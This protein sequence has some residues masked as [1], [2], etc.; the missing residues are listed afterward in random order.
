MARRGA[1][2]AIGAR[3]I[4]ILASFLLTFVVARLLD[5]AEA[6]TFFL[7]FT[8][9]AIAATFGRFGTDN[10]ALKLVGGASTDVQRDV[11]RLVVITVAA[12]GLAVVVGVSVVVVMGLRLPGVDNATI[13]VVATAVIPQAL[14]VLAGALLR[15][16]G[17]LVVGTFAE[18]GSLPTFA[19]AGMLAYA[20]IGEVTLGGSLYCLAGASWLTAVWSSG[21]AFAAMRSASYPAAGDRSASLGFFRRYFGQLFPMMGTSLI[22]Y[23]V[24]W[25]PIYLLTAVG[26]LEAV[27]FYT[28]AARLAGFVGLIPAIQVSYLAPTFARLYQSGEIASLNA[29]A[30]RSASLALAVAALPAAALI[31]APGF[32]LHL[33]YGAPYEDASVALILL[34]VGVIITVVAGQVNQ[35]MLLC[36]LE[37]FALWLNIALLAIWLIAG[38][39]AADT[40]GLLGV[41]GVSVL[42]TLV[43]QGSALVRLRQKASIRSY[44]RV[45]RR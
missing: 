7:I 21:A 36:D 38:Y 17:R 33:L 4:S 15:A 40:W 11:R 14:S 16:R 41:V 43:Y 45:P 6:G 3:G 5:V 12:S 44:F 26:D 32:I 23:V 42:V 29:L 9:L 28:V 19:T 10:L 35:L 25:V 31:V 20:A 18:L 1:I 30:T 24:T 2:G 22:F 13:V 34:T 8:S 39:Y 37:R 27:S